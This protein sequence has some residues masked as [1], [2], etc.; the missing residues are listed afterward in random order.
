MD[1][2]EHLTNQAKGNR[3][4]FIEVENANIIKQRKLKE[5]RLRNNLELRLD[6]KMD[7]VPSIEGDD[8][9]N[10]VTVVSEDVTHDDD[11][12]NPSTDDDDNKKSKSSKAKTPSNKKNEDGKHKMGLVDPTNIIN[13]KC[14]VFGCLLLEH[15]K[16]VK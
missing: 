13:V 10:E 7:S 2:T 11:D 9:E 8:V 12:N 4:S 3:K 1:I 5:E 15:A 14:C 6:D 16:T